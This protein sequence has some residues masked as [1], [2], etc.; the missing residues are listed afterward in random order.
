MLFIQRKKPNLKRSST[1]TPIKKRTIN[2]F[3]MYIIK[4]ENV[5]SLLDTVDIGL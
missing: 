2:D 4:K 1:E 5:Q 3:K